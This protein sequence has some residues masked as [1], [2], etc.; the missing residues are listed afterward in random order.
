[1]QFSNP[2]WLWAL[3][4]LSI[5]LAVHLLSRRE[6]AVID[7]GSIR[8]LRESPTARFRQVRLNEI[9]LLALRCLLV[10]L[11]TLL[12]AGLQVRGIGEG[13]K[14]VVVDEG[15]QDSEKIKTLLREFSD[16]GF[17]IRL[18]ADGF[19][20]I[21]NAKQAVFIR[22]YWT[23]VNELSS[24]PV[25]SVVVLSYNYLQKFKGERVSMPPHFKWITYDVEE[26]K[27]IAGKVMMDDDSVWV[28]NGFTSSAV[29]RFHTAINAAG[30]AADS[31][32]VRDQR[33]LEITIVRDEGFDHD[34]QILVAA[35][36]AIGTVTPHRITTVIHTPD[37]TRDSLS[38]VVF[39]L[40]HRPAVMQEGN[41]NFVFRLC[42]GNHIPLLIAPHE[43]SGY[44]ATTGTETWIISKRLNRKT[45]LE[46]DLPLHLARILLPALPGY[47]DRR[48]MPEPMMWSKGNLPAGDAVKAEAGTDHTSRLI[49]VL[50]L[51]MLMVERLLAF[52]RHQ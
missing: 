5:P 26:K 19:P 20:P 51:I 36:E 32:P 50:L 40:T 33:E 31:V 52:N 3:A 48:T 37:E 16:R 24:Q 35:L 13:L 44:C 27:Y 4:G 29:T 15:M 7:I 47:H 22:D 8:F 28:R 25:D 45:A 38:G 21:A 6:G 12:L 18:M 42:E 23:A 10:I 14:W 49:L 9:A 30:D 39:W 2:T 41:I 1:M 46:D 34:Y 17:D 11:L 43:A